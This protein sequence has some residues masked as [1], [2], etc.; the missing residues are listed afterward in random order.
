MGNR[1]FPEGLAGVIAAQRSFVAP[2]LWE[3]QPCRE[4]LGTPFPLSVQHT[5]KLSLPV[6][7][8]LGET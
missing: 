8:N 6:V 2:H 7:L 5:S 1:P 4:V 3:L